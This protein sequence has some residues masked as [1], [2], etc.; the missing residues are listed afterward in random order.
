MLSKNVVLGLVGWG[1]SGLFMFF[2]NHMPQIATVDIAAITEQFIKQ[3]AQKNLSPKEKQEAIQ[4]FSHTLEESI[5]KLST[6]KSLVIFPK[7]AVLKGAKDYTPDLKQMMH[8]E[9]KA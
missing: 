8:L 3:E 9:S 4:T 6:T 7:E 1:V 5:E 2:V